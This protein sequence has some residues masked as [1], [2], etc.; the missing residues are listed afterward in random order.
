MSSFYEQNPELLHLC[1]FSLAALKMLEEVGEATVEEISTKCNIPKS[2]IDMVLGCL[3]QDGYIVG[4][5]RKTKRYA[6]RF[7]D[8]E[9]P[10]LRCKEDKARQSTP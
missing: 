4:H 3:K 6:L 9:L 8:P 7:K 10:C 1:N 2:R 5:G